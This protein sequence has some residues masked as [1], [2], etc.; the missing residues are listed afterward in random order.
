M[1]IVL[2]PEYS[3]TADEARKMCEQLYELARRQCTGSEAVDHVAW[4]S[5][6]LIEALLAE[7]K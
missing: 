6:R 4:R 3:L 1:K 5:A 7:R 2:V